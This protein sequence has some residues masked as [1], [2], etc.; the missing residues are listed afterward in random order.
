MEVLKLNIEDARSGEPVFF[1]VVF[2]ENAVRMYDLESD[3]PYTFTIEEFLRAVQEV[4]EKGMTTLKGNEAGH[5]RVFMPGWINLEFLDK[6]FVFKE[7]DF[8]GLTEEIRRGIVEK[9]TLHI[10]L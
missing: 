3:F 1:E 10:S 2:S 9:M 6:Y 8:Y 4:Q 7:E 5:L